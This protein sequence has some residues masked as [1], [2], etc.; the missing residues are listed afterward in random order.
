[1]L[2]KVIAASVACRM[3]ALRTPKPSTRLRSRSTNASATI[4]VA[5][6][7]AARIMPVQAKNSL[8][9]CGRLSSL[10]GDMEAETIAAIARIDFASIV[11]SIASGMPPR[12]SLFVRFGAMC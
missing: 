3:G 7:P 4:G 5:G 12:T 9:R 11:R 1:V 2:P 8:P 10:G 6:A